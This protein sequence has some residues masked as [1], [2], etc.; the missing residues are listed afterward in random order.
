[1]NGNLFRFVLVP[2]I[3]V[4]VSVLARLTRDKLAK[5]KYDSSVQRPGKFDGCILRIIQGLAIFTGIFALFGLIIN[6]PV[7]TMV[8]F[9]LTIAFAGIIFLLKREYNL[10]Y[11]ENSEYFVLNHKNKEYK[12]FYEDIVDWRP[13]FNEIS[14]LDKTREDQKYIKVNIAM[15]KPE[16]L[17]RKIAEMTF[18]GRF[19]RQN[20]LESTDPMREQEIN[21]F[22]NGYNYGYLMDDLESD[23]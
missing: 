3:I 5:P 6:E 18:N 10:S 16:I 1:M 7:M 19:P 9:V 8:F 13:S 20:H 2:L 21:N 23:F 22:L 11:E 12:V 14:I 15:V 17:L 4:T